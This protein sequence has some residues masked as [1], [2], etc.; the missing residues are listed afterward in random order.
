M[1]TL[2]VLNVRVK[3]VIFDAVN[4]LNT[5]GLAVKDIINL[6]IMYLKISQ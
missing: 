5:H 4:G 6:E 1:N 2:N 3:L